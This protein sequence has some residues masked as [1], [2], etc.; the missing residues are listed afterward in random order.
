MVGL[1]LEQGVIP[2]TMSSIQ[3]NAKMTMNIASSGTKIK[4]STDTDMK[5]TTTGTSTTDVKTTT[6]GASNNVKK[7]LKI[8]R[9]ATVHHKIVSVCPP[10]NTSKL[11]LVL[12]PCFCIHK[13]TSTCPCCLCKKFGE[14]AHR[15]YVRA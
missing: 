12:D 10:K 6:F 1:D 2:G 7:Q 15:A 3:A 4:A 14:G 8:A 5:T 9:S 13:F 11:T